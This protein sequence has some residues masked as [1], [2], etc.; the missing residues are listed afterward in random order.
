MATLMIGR[1]LEIL[2][3]PDYRK[4]EYIGHDNLILDIYYLGIMISA[5]I[6]RHYSI[7]FYEEWVCFSAL[8]EIYLSCSVVYILF[9]RVSNLVA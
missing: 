1:I 2:V 9:K 3:E 6:N 7:K 4:S 8:F 5:C